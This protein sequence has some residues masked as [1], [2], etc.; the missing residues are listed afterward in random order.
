ME[1]S[2]GDDSESQSA[3]INLNEAD[4]AVLQ[5]I[6]GIGPKKAEAIIKYR[7]EHGSFQSVDELKNVTGIGAGIIT[8]LKEIV[9]V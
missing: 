1:K 5:S 9:S 6:S 4:I 3:E 8:K 2:S 7:Q